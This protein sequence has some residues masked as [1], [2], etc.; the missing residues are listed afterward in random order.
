[1]NIVYKKK[2]LFCEKWVEANITHVRDVWRGDDMISFRDVCQKIGYS[3]ALL[4]EYNAVRS[5]LYA[6]RARDTTQHPPSQPASVTPDLTAKQFRVLLTEAKATQ[7][8]SVHFWQNKYNFEV[9]KY[10]WLMP[11]LCTKEERLRLLQW[12]IFHNIYPTNILLHKM[13]IK[14]CNRCDYCNEIDYVEHF[15]WRCTKL[16]TFWHTVKYQIY[17]VTGKR[18]ELS[19][20]DVMFGY[21]VEKL[22]VTKEERRRRRI[23]HK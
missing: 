22:S 10:Y 5:A 14:D 17:T 3:S 6:T 9:N 15:F 13:K 16:S 21:Q 12:K 4:F 20:S 7:P 18:I 8:C 11:Y 19:E 1:M 23:S 2:S